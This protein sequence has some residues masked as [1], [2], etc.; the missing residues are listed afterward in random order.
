[1]KPTDVSIYSAV[2]PDPLDKH[3]QAFMTETTPRNWVLSSRQYKIDTAVNKIKSA[4][5]IDPTGA[6]FDA[7]LIKSVTVSQRKTAKFIDSTIQKLSSI[8]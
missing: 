8:D 5:G 1:M 3:G 2:K 7:E 6:E 4:T